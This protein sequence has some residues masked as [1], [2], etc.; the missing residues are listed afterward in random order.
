ME[1]VSA[2]QLLISALAFIPC[3][4]MGTDYEPASRREVDILVLVWFLW[5]PCQ[6]PCSF[7]SVSYL[8]NQSMDFDQTCRGQKS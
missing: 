7:V 2:I 3:K 1:K 6:H 4:Y 5:H 8:L